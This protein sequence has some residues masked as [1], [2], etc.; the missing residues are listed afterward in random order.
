MT[1]VMTVIAGTMNARQI[2]RM[3]AMPTATVMRMLVYSN[4]TTSPA[5]PT[6]VVRGCFALALTVNRKGMNVRG[7]RTATS[8]VNP[9]VQRRR[10]VLRARR[11]VVGRGT[12]VTVPAVTATF[13]TATLTPPKTFPPV[14]ATLPYP[15]EFELPMQMFWTLRPFP[16]L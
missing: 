10:S 9:A 6:S 4:M 15:K 16:K 3:I 8:A 11:N 12:V 5:F 7:Q 13:P 14:P 1:A 2:A